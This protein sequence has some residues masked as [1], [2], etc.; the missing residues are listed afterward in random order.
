VQEDVDTCPAAS[1]KQDQLLDDKFDILPA[2]DY[3]YETLLFP[4]FFT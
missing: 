2:F 4:F 3:V 1:R